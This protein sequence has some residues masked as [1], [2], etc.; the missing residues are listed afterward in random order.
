MI[1]RLPR[2]GWGGGG[3]AIVPRAT[4]IKF[5]SRQPA[6]PESRIRR[7]SGQWVVMGGNDGLDGVS[8]QPAGPP[9]TKRQLAVGSGKP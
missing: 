6:S 9:S 8:S 7:I 2:G 1:D 3:A 5:G 4:C